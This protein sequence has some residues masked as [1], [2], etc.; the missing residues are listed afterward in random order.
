MRVGRLV[1]I[2]ALLSIGGCAPFMKLPAPDPVWAATAGSPYERAETASLEQRAA[3]QRARAYIAQSLPARSDA[4]IRSLEQQS[5][6]CSFRGDK[7]FNCIYSKAQPRTACA[8]SL[9][10]SIDVDFPYEH[11]GAIVIEKDDIDVA[12]F[13][14]ADRDNLDERGCFPL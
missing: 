9:R 12:A 8:A 3:T 6:F 1:F 14:A 2:A 5:F 10:V 11:D 4:F 13:V 7:R